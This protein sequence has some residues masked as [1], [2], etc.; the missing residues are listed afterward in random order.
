M[1]AKE[2]I[3]L[4]RA[5]ALLVLLLILF[6]GGRALVNGVLDFIQAPVVAE[7]DSAIGSNSAFQKG[8][9]ATN[10]AIDGLQGAARE[11]KAKSEAAVKSAGEPNYNR[12]QGIL[13]APAV[14]E[15]DYERAVNRIDRELGLQ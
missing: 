9:E 15:T 4:V 1:P 8:A 11:K 6:F 5:I 14:G 2:M 12:A 3:L 10:T 13:R 7:R